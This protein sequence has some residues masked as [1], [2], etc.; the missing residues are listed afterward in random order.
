MSQLKEK[1]HLQRMSEAQRTLIRTQIGNRA[2]MY[3]FIVQGELMYFL[4]NGE[5]VC[6]SLKQEN[7]VYR[8][9]F[10]RQIIEIDSAT[11]ECFIVDFNRNCLEY[12]CVHD[13]F[14][15][16]LQNTCYSLLYR[17]LIRERIDRIDRR[18]VRSLRIFFTTRKVVGQIERAGQS[19][20]KSPLG[21]LSIHEMVRGMKLLIADRISAFFIWSPCQNIF[22]DA[23]LSNPIP[24]QRPSV[25]QFY[26]MGLF[27][28]GEFQKPLPSLAMI[29]LIMLR[30]VEN[31][32]D[33]MTGVFRKRIAN[34]FLRMMIG[35]LS[36]M[37]GK[38]FIENP[39]GFRQAVP[40]MDDLLDSCPKKTNLQSQSGSPVRS[41]AGCVSEMI[42]MDRGRVELCQKR[43]SDWFDEQRR[44]EQE[45]QRRLEQEEH[46]RKQ[47]IQEFQGGIARIKVEVSQTQKRKCILDEFASGGGAMMKDEFDET[48]TRKRGRESDA[49]EFDDTCSFL[50]LEK[51]EKFKKFE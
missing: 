2:A 10:N 38:K 6:V 26:G 39:I 17:L 33:P 48:E 20:L 30:F 40:T 28:T 35:S 11:G 14:Q 22:Q 43:R 42:A 24:S 50:K 9:W 46:Q 23:L 49:F 5:L 34:S 25:D 3:P 31:E 8:F 18:S 12:F 47:S 4:Q 45:E 27:L 32:K 15:T 29:H 41:V 36:S 16:A 1:E 51:F 44:L 21:C 37:M 7:G 19:S 13:F